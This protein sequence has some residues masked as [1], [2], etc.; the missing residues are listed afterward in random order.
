MEGKGK[1]GE[2]KEK[3][4]IPPRRGQIKEKIFEELGEKIL[5]MTFGGGGDA[6]KNQVFPSSKD[7]IFDPPTKRSWIDGGI[8]EQALANN[9]FGERWM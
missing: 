9:G 4:M 2:K 5:N 1:S 7:Y 3:N 6:K 8:I